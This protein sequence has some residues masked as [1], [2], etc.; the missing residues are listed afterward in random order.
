MIDEVLARIVPTDEERRRVEGIVQR[1]QDAVEAALDGC[2][3]ATIQGSIAKDT[4]LSGSTDVDLFILFPTDADE[5]T[6]AD[7]TR[8]IGEQVLDGARRRYAQ[9]PYTVGEFEGLT[10]DLVPAYAVATASQKMSAVDRTPFHTAWVHKHL[11]DEMRNEVRLAK[12]WLKGIGAYGAETAIAGFSGYLVEVLIALLGSFENLVIW[13]AA[14]ATP[15]RL[16]GPD[17]HVQDDVS[18]LIVVDPVDP[19]RNCAAA[20]SAD[21]IAH[22]KEA[23]RTY[24][25]SPDLR[26]FF[27]APPASAAP[28]VLQ[29]RLRD[30]AQTWIGWVLPDAPERLDIV[31]P[32]FQKAADRIANALG[33]AGFQPA[34][35]HTWTDDDAV[36]MQWLCAATPL[37]E[38]RLHRGPPVDAAPNAQ[39][40]REKWEAHDGAG[41]VHEDNGRLA[42]EVVIPHRTPAAWLEA[43]LE[44]LP[45]GKHVERCRRNGRLITDPAVGPPWSPIVTDFILGRRP[46][47]R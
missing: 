28:D 24:Q 11:D 31:Y 37:P 34:A 38:T 1:L 33:D 39:R 40:F 4:W 23:A 21:T 32:Q 44:K 27:P 19:A 41:P 13:F 18:P 22:C 26:F 5:L 12:R 30:Q 14:D 47:E 9:H 36:Y 42:V 2:A 43:N 7:T 25:A 20:V 29:H 3:T 35:T 15:R 8:R 16:S 17:D 46:W 10:V 6:L 45:L